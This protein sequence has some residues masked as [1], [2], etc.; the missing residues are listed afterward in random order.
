MDSQMEIDPTTAPV[1]KKGSRILC[2]NYDKFWLIPSSHRIRI[3]EFVDNLIVEP[4]LRTK[5]QNSFINYCYRQISRLQRAD[6]KWSPSSTK[7]M[8][9]H[10]LVV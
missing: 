3:V 4:E 9:E 6:T 10:V 5:F 7:E 2:H 8:A 1:P